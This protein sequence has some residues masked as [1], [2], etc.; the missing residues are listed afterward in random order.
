MLSYFTRQQPLVENK[1]TLLK[2]SSVVGTLWTFIGMITRPLRQ[3]FPSGCGPMNNNSNQ[4][5][6]EHKTPKLDV[7]QWHV[8]HIRGWPVYVGWHRKS[9][10]DL[11]TEGGWGWGAGR[12]GMPLGKMITD[13][14]VAQKKRKR[15]K[16]DSSD[17]CVSKQSLNI[18]SSD[19]IICAFTMPVSSASTEGRHVSSSSSLKNT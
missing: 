7:S 3:I 4:Q 2:C 17:I 9:R 8:C 10:T 11:A 13:D 18:F 5:V 14:T 16:N 12:S 15:K 1:K 6:I 19:Y